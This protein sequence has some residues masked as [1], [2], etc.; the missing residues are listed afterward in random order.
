M[1]IV[2]L[3]VLGVALASC[4]TSFRISVQDPAVIDLPDDALSF[5]VVNNVNNENSPEKVV[6]SILTGQQINGNVEAA[7]R[8]VNGVHRAIENSRTLSSVSVTADSVHAEDGSIN[9]SYLDTIA[10]QNNLDGFIEL[11]EIRTVAPV[12]G[13]I[14][15]NMEGKSSTTLEGT[16]FVN[17][18]VVQDN[19]AQ[20]RWSV[21]KKYRIPVSGGTSVLDMLGDVQKK[22]EYYRKLGFELGYS[23]GKLIY[24]NWVWVN[25]K[26]YNKGSK[27]LK[28]A[29]PMIYKGN[30]D[31]AEKQLQYALD[32]GSDK[33]RGRA[34]YNLALVNE[35]Q[36]ELD[37]AIQ[38]AETAALEY[39]NKMANDYLV[40][41]RQ[42]KRQV[43]ILKNQ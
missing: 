28:R 5:G 2:L 40:T 1:R 6:G 21:R 26:F 15:A 35:G 32:S 12:G 41:L 14:A 3:F 17:Y 30:W 38:H 9:W 13:T 11:A 36:G 33:V 22:R 10:K 7:K 24:P 4:K 31:I 29:K 16:A 37:E 19:W 20:E 8:M 43:E 27:E 18:Y 23:A 42:R 39:G 25:R 34:H